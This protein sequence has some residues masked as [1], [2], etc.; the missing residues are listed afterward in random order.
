M[1]AAEDR[2]AAAE[3][4]AALAR[5]QVLDWKEKLQ[6]AQMAVEAAEKQA[7]DQKFTVSELQKQM[8]VRTSL[9]LS[10]CCVLVPTFDPQN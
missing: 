6:L 7:S 10:Y 5:K 1:E 8:N 2:A 4:D 9:D 3:N